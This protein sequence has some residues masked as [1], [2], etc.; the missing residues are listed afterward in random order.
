MNGDES[1]ELESG[2]ITNVGS[3]QN[4]T[5]RQPS[6]DLFSHHQASGQLQQEQLQRIN[7]DPDRVQV[8]LGEVSGHCADPP[9]SIFGGNNTSTREACLPS[10]NS[11]AYQHE[12]D[13][14]SSHIPSKS[15]GAD[16]N[17]A[18]NSRTYNITES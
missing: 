15:T 1:P 8:Q 11:V 18:V 10:T 5:P 13:I 4:E 7:Q 3:R 12:A 16:F 9:S 2:Y 14:Y 6:S 17:V